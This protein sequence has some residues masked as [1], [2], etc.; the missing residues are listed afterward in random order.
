MP[1]LLNMN[2]HVYNVI[3]SLRWPMFRKV[4]L[5]EYFFL[6]GGPQLWRERAV[7]LNYKGRMHS[8]L[9]SEQTRKICYS[10]LLQKSPWL[11][12]LSV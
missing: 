1:R 10:H 3:P 11:W 7:A 2:G 8:A 6:I 12:P 9:G 5:D 4:R